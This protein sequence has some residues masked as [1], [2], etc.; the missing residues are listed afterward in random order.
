MLG[1]LQENF[2]ILME[3]RTK[4][5]QKALLWLMGANRENLSGVG[6]VGTVGEVAL[7]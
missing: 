1:K 3:E 6:E 7:G 5:T 2:Q 4:Q